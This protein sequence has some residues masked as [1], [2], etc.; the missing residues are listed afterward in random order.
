MI[1]IPNPNARTPHRLNPHPRIQT[2]PPRIQRRI[3]HNQPLPR[4]PRRP[5]MHQLDAHRA[6]LDGL[7]DRKPERIIGWTVVEAA[8]ALVPGQLHKRVDAVDEFGV[9]GA[10]G[11]FGDTLPVVDVV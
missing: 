3:H 6:R 9:F 5:L 1:P 10:A 7:F 11:W 2:I 4:L 8:F